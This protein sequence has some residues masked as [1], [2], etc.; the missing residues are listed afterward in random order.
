MKPSIACASVLALSLAACGDRPPAT[1]DAAAPTGRSL[2]GDPAAP[3][4]FDPATATAPPVSGSLRPAVVEDVITFDGFG[5]AAFGAD[6]EQ[7]R[8]AWGADLGDAVPSEP[9]GCYSLTPQPPGDAGYGIAFMIEADRFARIDV[10]NAGYAAPGGGKVGMDR[11]DIERLYAGRIEATPHKYVEGAQVLRVR[12][13]E[14]ALVFETDTA[15]RV[16]GWRIGTP[17]QV[18]YVEGCG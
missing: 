13:G 6:Q 8:M 2:D 5:P 1:V 17:P 10:R 9:G 16:T 4:P 11:S 15:G 18:D 3:P 12:E 14:R 7:V